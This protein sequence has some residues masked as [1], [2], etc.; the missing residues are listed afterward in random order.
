MAFV[1]G[2]SGNPTGRPKMDPAI[3]AMFEAKGPDAFEVISRHLS[4]NDP[5]VALQAAQ[6]ILD[7]AYGKVPQAIEGGETPIQHEATI[8]VTGVLR[9]GDE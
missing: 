6:I 9:H 7:R 8:I 4:D 3:K 5:K 1:K 2:Q